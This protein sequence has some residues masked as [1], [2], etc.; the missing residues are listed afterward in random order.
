MPQHT[1]PAFLLQAFTADWGRPTGFEPEPVVLIE[2]QIWLSVVLFV[3]FAVLVVLRVFDGRRMTQLAG[4]FFRASSVGMLYREDNALTGRAS[5]LLLLNFLI[6]TPLFLWQVMGF[7][8]ALRGDLLQ[9]GLL[10][11]LLAVIY[12]IKLMITSLLGVIFDHREAATEYNY[13]ILLFNKTLGLLLFPVTVMLAYSRD[14]PPVWL[15]GFGL[16]AWGIILVYRLFRGVLIGLS[17]SGV[18]L[19]HIILY[20]CTLEILPFVVILKQFTG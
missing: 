7:F 20:L 4:G 19:Y 2:G 16:C 6:V 10:A 14:V 18:S 17:V 11:L 5:V 12:L 1:S 15:I 9:Y 13:N 8:G 3:A